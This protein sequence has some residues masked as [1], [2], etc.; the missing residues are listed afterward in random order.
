[1]RAPR[2]SVSTSVSVWLPPAGSEKLGTF[3]GSVSA[4]PTE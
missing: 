2:S 1:M 4:I 3:S